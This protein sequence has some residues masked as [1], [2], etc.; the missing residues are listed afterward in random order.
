M[1]LADIEDRVGR[2]ERMLRELAREL[3]KIREEIAA[4]LEAEASAM[5]GDPMPF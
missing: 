5:S 1:L 4:K 2:I 3:A